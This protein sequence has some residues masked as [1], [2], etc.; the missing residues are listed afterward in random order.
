MGIA[1]IAFSF[2]FSWDEACGSTAF[3]STYEPDTYLLEKAENVENYWK[4]VD[5]APILNVA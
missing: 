3:F 1:V 5:P 4:S 2:K